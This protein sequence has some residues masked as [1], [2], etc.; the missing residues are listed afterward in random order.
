MA[1]AVPSTFASGDEDGIEDDE[2][3]DDLSGLPQFVRNHES[4][5]TTHGVTRETYDP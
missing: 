2:V 5:E 1:R 3:S 4:D